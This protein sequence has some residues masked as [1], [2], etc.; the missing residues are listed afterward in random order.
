MSNRLYMAVIRLL[1]AE[2]L[3]ASH[4][5][6]IWFFHRCLMLCSYCLSLV[7]NMDNEHCRVSVNITLSLFHFLQCGLC[8]EVT[9]LFTVCVRRTQPCPHTNRQCHGLRAE[10]TEAKVTFVSLRLTHYFSSFLEDIPMN[11]YFLHLLKQHFVEGNGRVLW[12]KR[13]KLQTDCHSFYFYCVRQTVRDTHI[14]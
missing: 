5:C 3:K 4:V 10:A 12:Y 8:S 9:L 14:E 6:Q 2:W 13:Q 11:T 1:W 7:A